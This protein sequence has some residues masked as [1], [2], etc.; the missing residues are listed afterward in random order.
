MKLAGWQKS[1][2]AIGNDTQ[3]LE[4]IGKLIGTL[5]DKG[6]NARGEGVKSETA[7]F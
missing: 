4:N 2:R 7:G 1:E 5:A 3:L 6:R